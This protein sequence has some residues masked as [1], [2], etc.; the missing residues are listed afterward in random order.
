MSVR[1]ESPD[2]LLGKL[3]R[4]HGAGYLEALKMPSDAVG[5]LLIDCVCHDPRIDRQVESRCEYYASLINK[6]NVDI[7]P[8]EKHLKENDDTEDFGWNANLTVETLGALALIGNDDAAMIL[9]NYLSY[10]Y[11]WDWAVYDLLKTDNIE[12]TIGIAEVL[13]QRFG[14]YYELYEKL[15]SIDMDSLD[16]LCQLNPSLK[17]FSAKVS[18]DDSRRKNEDRDNSNYTELSLDEIFQV[19]DMGNWRKLSNII[20]S[21]VSDSD[22]AFLN[23][24][25]ISA[26]R[27]RAG[28]AAV[29]LG[30]IK[31]SESFECL[32]C[33]LEGYSGKGDKFPYV[34]ALNNIALFPKEICLET[35]R[36]WFNS[37]RYPISV[38]ARN[39]LEKYAEAKDI[40]MLINAIRTSL[41]DEVEKCY[42]LCSAVDALANFKNYGMIPEVEMIYQ[43]A[44]YSYARWRAVKTMQENASDEFWFKYSY[45]CL[46]D[47]EDWAV[48]L[49]LDSFESVDKSDTVLIERLQEIYEHS[50][51]DKELRDKINMLLSK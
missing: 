45:E 17:M 39:I 7:S 2:T 33:F 50:E 13:S 34:R 16:I 35:G 47:C 49:A 29:A 28:L 21:K 43:K 1:I 8:L 32:K 26:E 44:R 40:P 3:Q 48:N 18:L 37:C 24:I 22:V 46:F 9:R 11:W 30:K 10:G 27:F 6:M 15:S 20:A 5:P 51:D 12:Y 4:G 41:K 19:C 36:K 31:T 25:M 23:E 14:G 38:A 42:I